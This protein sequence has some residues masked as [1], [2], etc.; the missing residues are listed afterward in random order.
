MRTLTEFE[1][2][3]GAAVVKPRWRK[4]AGDMPEELTIEEIPIRKVPQLIDLRLDE[5]A[6]VE[7][8]AGLKKGDA[9]KLTHASYEE[10][11]DVGDAL[12]APFADAWLQRLTE[13]TSEMLDVAERNQALAPRA[14]G[15]SG[16]AHAVPSSADVPPGTS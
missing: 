1:R 11:L 6:L 4:S 16:S 15:L 7:F 14:A 3:D 12:N 8:Y 10:I 5:P 9:D 13:R 2:A